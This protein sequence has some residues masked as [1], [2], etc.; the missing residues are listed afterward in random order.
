MDFLKI[1]NL[2]D[3]TFDNKDLPRFVTTTWIKIYDQSEKITVL[4]KKLELR[5][6]C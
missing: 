1:I 5:H 6:Q 2:L 4:S 3:T